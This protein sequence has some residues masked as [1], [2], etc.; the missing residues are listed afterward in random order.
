MRSTLDGS[1]QRLAI[2]TLRTQLRELQGRN[3][4]DGAVVVLDNVSGYVLAWVGSSGSLSRAAQVDGVMARRQPGS[5]LK[6]F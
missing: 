1:L 4:E 3:V 2:D 5:A 6:P